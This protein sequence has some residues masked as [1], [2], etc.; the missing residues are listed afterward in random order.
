M[1]NLLALLA[2][3]VLAFA[4][5]GWYLGWYHVQ[6]TPTSDGHREIKVDVDTKKIR[7][8][9]SEGVSKGTQKV[10][11]WVNQKNGQP[12][13]HGQ[14]PRPG[15]QSQSGAPAPSGNGQSHIRFNQDGSV[16]YTG[17]ISVTVPGK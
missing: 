11:E 5:A 17:D 15:A 1:R 4:G 3:G 6:T 2:A 14:P 12:A 9:V 13:P 7:E 8:D 10:E 16:T